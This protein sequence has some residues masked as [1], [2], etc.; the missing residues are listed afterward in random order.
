MLGAIAGDV[1][2]SVY[3]HRPVK[4]ADFRPL[5][6]GA[7]RYTDDTVLTVATADAILGDG[8]YAA[9]YR[10]FG[11][12]HPNAGYGKSFREWL[13]TPGGGPYGSWG[14]GSAMR[15]SP[16]GWAFDTE[17]KVLAEAERS[18]AVTHDH[19]EGIRGAQAV[20]LAVFL[21][22]NGA[23]K[24][25]VR[26]E[27]ASRFGY[28]VARTVDEIRPSYRF[29]VSCQESVPEAI[30][31]FLDS[32]NFED[33]VRLA[34]SLG[35]DADTQAA[36]AGSIAEVAYGGVPEGILLWVLDR[37]PGDLMVVVRAF[38]ERYPYVMPGTRGSTPAACAGPS[39]FHR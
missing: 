29:Q 28:D 13:L 9:S 37:M 23:E 2:G 25:D 34:I 14:N 17:A 19:P 26:A 10:R 39:R 20:A 31:A 7:S 35:G 11:R 16:I 18:A 15:V 38:G 5:L 27:I 30:V 4:T 33:A 6:S 36:I 32:G 24:A 12:A 1:I 3:E 21:C 22:R 8:D